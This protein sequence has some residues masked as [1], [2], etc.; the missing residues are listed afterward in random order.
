MSKSHQDY[1][2]LAAA[3]IFAQVLSYMA[4]YQVSLETKDLFSLISQIFPNTFIADE[5]F[6]KYAIPVVV[7][8]TTQYFLAKKKSSNLR[9][10]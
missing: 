1:F 2:Q 6:L 4:M 5:A 7:F 9:V 8:V 10:Q 3:H